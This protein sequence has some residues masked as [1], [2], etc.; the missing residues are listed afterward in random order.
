MSSRSFGILLVSIATIMWRSAGLFV[1][2]L[3]LDA[4]TVLGWRSFFGG[5]TLLLI[6]LYRAQMRP[7]TTSTAIPL[8]LLSGLVAAISVYGYIGA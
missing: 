7:T 3:D 1:R 4:W 5:A 6:T 8:Y 2:L